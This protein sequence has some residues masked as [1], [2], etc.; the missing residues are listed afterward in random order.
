MV[1]TLTLKGGDLE[2]KEILCIIKQHCPQSFSFVPNLHP[3]VWKSWPSISKPFQLFHIMDVKPLWRAKPVSHCRWGRTGKR[4]C[5]AS[6]GGQAWCARVAQK[7][8]FSGD[9]KTE[10]FWR[11][12]GYAS[13][14][15]FN[16]RKAALIETICGIAKPTLTT[17]IFGLL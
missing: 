17:V 1:K 2:A 9:M 6:G 13:R 8:N 16:N 3:W 7:T 4:R 10:C 11:E 5:K 12:G 15:E 14:K